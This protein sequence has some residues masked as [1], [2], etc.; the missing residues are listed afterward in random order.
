VNNLIVEL[1]L[2][3]GVKC[4]Y[5]YERF[6]CHKFLLSLWLGYHPLKKNCWTG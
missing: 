3:D 1:V 4:K 6:L 5:L 2:L